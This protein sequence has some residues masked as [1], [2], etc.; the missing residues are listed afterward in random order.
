MHQ[1]VVEE[2]INVQIYGETATLLRWL[3][4]SGIA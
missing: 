1:A 4:H 2:C 3:I